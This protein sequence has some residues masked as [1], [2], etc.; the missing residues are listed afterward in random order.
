MTDTCQK[1]GN[2]YKQVAQHWVGS[3]S[4]EHP[5]LSKHQRE[6]VVGLIMGDGCINKTGKGGGNPH[7]V[8]NMTSQNYLKYVDDVFGVFG[9]GVSLHKTKEEAAEL[10]KNSGFRNNAKPENYKDIYKWISM[11]HPQLKEFERWYSTGEKVWPDGIQLTPTVL[12]HWYC[13]DGCFNQS[14]KRIQISMSNEIDNKDKVD[15]MFEKVGL[16][17]PSN[18]NIH[19]RKDGSMSCCAHFTVDQSKELWNYMGK[20]LPDFE[21]KWPDEYKS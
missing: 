4:C 12:K 2:E 8:C 1:C 10:V 5:P 19:E 9:K 16:P 6:I 13:G 18:Y 7:I 21:Y 11:R 14:R 20:P 15:K 17:S 3:S